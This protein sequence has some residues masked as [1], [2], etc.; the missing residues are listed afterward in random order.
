MVPG[1]SYRIEVRRA[2][3]Q[4][5]F[6]IDYAVAWRMGTPADT[7][8]DG[9]DDEWEVAFGLDYTTWD[10]GI[11]NDND[12]L[13]ALGEYQAGTDPDIDDTDGDGVLDGAEVLAG[14]DPLD[15]AQVP[16]TSVPVGLGASIAGLLILLVIGWHSYVQRCKSPIK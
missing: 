7:D 6:L 3:G 13:Q 1:R 5:D 4:S 11:D 14:S 9:L 12:G 2:E 10:S 15:P 8:G 16:G